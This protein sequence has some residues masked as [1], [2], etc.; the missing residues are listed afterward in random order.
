MTGGQ[1]KKYENPGHSEGKDLK[2]KSEGTKK[3]KTVVHIVPY[4]KV[5]GFMKP[6][7]DYYS[8]TNNMQQRGFVRMILEAVVEELDQ[9]PDRRFTFSE[10]KYLQ[11]WYTRAS[12]E[13]RD[14]LKKQIQSGQFEVATGGWSSSDEASPNFEDLI[15]N[16]MIGHQFL[17]NEFNYTPKIGWNLD[18]FAHSNTNARIF[19]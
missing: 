15:N 14:K 10:V 13:L 6:V 16:I 5:S 2:P 7:D 1:E 8:G 17:Q 9:H 18:A 19:A 12:Q 11:M 3:K 4:S